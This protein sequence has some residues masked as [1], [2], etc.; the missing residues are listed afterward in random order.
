GNPARVIKYRFD[1]ETIQD[2]LQI[3]WWDFKL[4][5]FVN[6]YASIQQLTDSVFR[7]ELMAQIG[8]SWYD[9]SQHYLV[10]KSERVAEGATCEFIGAEVN[11]NF[12]KHDNLPD[13]FKFF[14]AQA[15]APLGTQI[16]LIKDIFKFSGLTTDKTSMAMPA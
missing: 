1:E 5:Y 3:R 12:I 10:F 2:L 16:Y 11:G 4:A 14:I 8:A 15:K 13:E 9:H 6:H 7:K